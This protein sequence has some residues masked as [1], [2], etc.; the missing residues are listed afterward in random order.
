MFDLVAI[1]DTTRIER[2]RLEVQSVTLLFAHFGERVRLAI[3]R[4]FYAR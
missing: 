2:E 1:L 3:V 4:T